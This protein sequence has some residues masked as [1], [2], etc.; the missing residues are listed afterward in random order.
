MRKERQQR[1]LQLLREANWTWDIPRLAAFAS[2]RL[3][4]R[5]RDSG[6]YGKTAVEY[7]SRSVFQVLNGDHDPGSTPTLYELV[8]RVIEK[9]IQA[10]L[11]KE[12]EQALR[13]R[14]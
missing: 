9:N 1:L 3:A 13:R 11:Q 2:F 14:A 8:C 6:R 7:M 12:V 10:D 5:D 4:R